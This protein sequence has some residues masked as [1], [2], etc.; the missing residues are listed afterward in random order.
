VHSETRGW[1]FQ[2]KHHSA[3]LQSFG[4]GSSAQNADLVRFA[5]VVYHRVE[6]DLDG[7][8]LRTQTHAVGQGAKEMVSAV[9]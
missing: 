1:D 9:L 2:S 8:Y 3:A 5:A 7:T 6:R 4:R